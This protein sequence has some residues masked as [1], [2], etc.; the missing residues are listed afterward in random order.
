MSEFSSGFPVGI[1]RHGRVSVSENSWRKG[2]RRAAAE[3]GNFLESG[4]T[5]GFRG[6][7]TAGGGNKQGAHD[8]LGKEGRAS[9]R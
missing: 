6:P 7:L 3:A 8:G 4:I 9:G 1:M 2:G 5:G